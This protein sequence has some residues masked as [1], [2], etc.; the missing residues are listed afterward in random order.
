ME[1]PVTTDTPIAFRPD[2]DL[3]AWLEDR[4]RRTAA[5]LSPAQQARAELGM[6]RSVLA[7]E[8]SRLRLHLAEASCLADVVLGEILDQGVAYSTPLLYHQA[9][10]AFTLARSNHP[11]IGPDMSSYG[12][13]WEIDE[14]RLLAWLRRLTPAQDAALRDAL[15][16]WWATD[17]EAT[18][19]GFAKV[20][21][22]V[23]EEKEN[24]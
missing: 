15:S 8:L 19:A 1:R 12:A 14:D 20:G 3:H 13:K 7:A 21:L 4:A 22:A 5:E 10:D 23:T 11:G 16:R 2:V 17:S 9:S 6:W 24:C 18:V